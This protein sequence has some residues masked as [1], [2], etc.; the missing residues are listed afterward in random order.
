MMSDPTIN[1]SYSGCHE[2]GSPDISL[3]PK[4]NVAHFHSIA[5]QALTFFIGKKGAIINL[6]PLLHHVYR[7]DDRCASFYITRRLEHSSERSRLDIQFTPRDQ[8]PELDC[9]SASGFNSVAHDSIK[10]QLKVR[11]RCLQQRLVP[12]NRP[13]EF[14][15]TFLLVQR[16]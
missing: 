9:A 1:P 10:S 12:I 4:Q 15:D 11:M 3:S 8:L 5:A 14:S 6:K 7:I 2:H 16:W 13:K